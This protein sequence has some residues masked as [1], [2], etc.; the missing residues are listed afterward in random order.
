MNTLYAWE[1]RRR[2]SMQKTIYIVA[3]GPEAYIPKLE[4]DSDVLW[5]GVDRGV[6]YLLQADIC[7]HIAF[8]DFDSVN[9]AEWAVINKQLTNINRYLP[10]K[11]ETDMELALLWAVKQQPALIRIFGGTGGR[12]D[13]FLA[14]V[15]LMARPSILSSISCTIEIIDE[16]NIISILRPGTYTV[17]KLAD[18]Q[19]ISFLPLSREIIDI[20][21]IGFKYPLKDQHVSRGST[22]CMSNEL[23]QSKGTFSFKEGILIMVRSMD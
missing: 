11:D 7:P 4:N 9:E 10:E 15:F 20:T 3:G 19:Y 23:I 12:L 8:G 14:N 16:K 22:L 17:E 2:K 6:Y 21:L 13:H 18:K 5:V 1:D